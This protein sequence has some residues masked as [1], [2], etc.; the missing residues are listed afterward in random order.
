MPLTS[1]PHWDTPTDA[2]AAMTAHRPLS[3]AMRSNDDIDWPVHSLM[4]SLHDLRGL[5]L[6]R[7]PSAV[8]K[9]MVF[10]HCIG[11]LVMAGCACASLI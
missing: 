11:N 6:P 8:I 7:L 3:S 4:L 2:S 1:M 9:L 5:L 10:F